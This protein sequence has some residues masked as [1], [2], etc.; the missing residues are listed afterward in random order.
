MTQKSSRKIIWIATGFIALVL[1]ISLYA[2]QALAVCVKDSE[3]CVEGAETRIINGLEV[4]RD[5]WRYAAQ[6]TCSGTE[7]SPDS[8]CQDLI[9]QGCSPVSQTCDETSCVQTYECAVGTGTTQ[10]GVG[11]DTQN[12]AVNGLKFDTSYDP[13]PD[14]GKAASNMAAMESAVTGMIKNDASC[15]EDPPGS[16]AYVCAEPILIFNGSGKRCRKDSLGFNKCCNLN[17]WGVDAGLNQCDQEEEVLG[18]ARQA[19]RAHYV[20][21]YCTHSNVFGCYAHAY[22][23]CTFNSKIGRIVQ[24]QGRTQLNKGWG[25]AKNPQCEGFTDTELTNI[26]FELIDFSEYFADA[27]ANAGSPPSSAQMESIVNTYINT[28]KNS[29]CSQFDPNYPNC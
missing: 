2:Q 6:Y 21:K 18:Y 20:G 25:S 23:Y 5:C 29:G 15:V 22:V 24:E 1:L 27:F 8:H 10:T 9:D 28:L 14:F 3:M 11:C 4:T 19:G 16:G 12:V 13:S 17:G 7:L 26:N